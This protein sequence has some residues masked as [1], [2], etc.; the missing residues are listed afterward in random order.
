MLRVLCTI[1]L[2][3]INQ[4]KIIIFDTIVYIATKYSEIFMNIVQDISLSPECISSENGT[5][6][7]VPKK[8]E[9]LFAQFSKYNFAMCT[10]VR[11]TE[12]CKCRGK[13]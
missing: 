13:G 5:W 1:L 4:D 9:V 6:T 3:S 8:E 2:G 12:M 10:S 11:S 7:L